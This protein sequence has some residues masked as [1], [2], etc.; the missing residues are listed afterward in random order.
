MVVENDLT[1]ITN[2]I[3]NSMTV[4]TVII[5]IGAI[6][7]GIYQY[8][9]DQMLR[10]KDTLLPL[11]SEFEDSSK[12][13]GLAKELLDGFKYVVGLKWKEQIFAE[14]QVYQINEKRI[15]RLHKDFD[16]SINDI[17]EIEIRRS[18]DALLDFFGK[19][20]YEQKGYVKKMR[21]IDQSKKLYSS[22]T[23]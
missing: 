8:R 22:T 7:F 20:G 13:M 1:S 21:Q 4:I 23:F 19:L 11:I 15:F 12:N 3:T 10:R 2:V 14:Y 5:S 17:G 9:K 18:F 16:D 6:I